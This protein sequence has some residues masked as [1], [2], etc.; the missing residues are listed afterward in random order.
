[1]K[2]IILNEGYQNSK[3]FFSSGKNDRVFI[4]KKSFIDL[5]NCAGSLILGH[6][7]HLYKNKMKEYLI[8][9]NSVFAHP[10]VHALKFSKTI[11]KIFP[12]FAKIIFYFTKQKKERRI[13]LI[14]S[15]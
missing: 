7:N 14:L 5:S 1:M 13:R 12:N 2:N 10:N 4:K 15:G 8:K 6:N 11:Q 9:N 3:F